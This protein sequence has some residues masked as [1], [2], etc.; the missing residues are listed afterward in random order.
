[1]NRDLPASF[2]Y[3]PAS[4][5]GLFAK[6]MA[7]EATAL[8][9][10]LEDSVSPA[11]KNTARDNL[12]SFLDAHPIPSKPVWVR[13]NALSDS[14]QNIAALDV[15][16]VLDSGISEIVVPK[17]EVASLRS[18]AQLAPE[19][20]VIGM[21]ETARGYLQLA[22]IAAE[23][24][25]AGLALGRADLLSELRIDPRLE[26]AFEQLA[27][28]LTVACAALGLPAPIAPAHL[29]LVKGDAA[30]A[31]ARAV[32]ERFFDLGF[33]SQ[34]SLHPRRCSTINSVFTPSEADYLKATALMTKFNTSN[35]SFVA[36][37]GQFVDEAVIRRS[38]EIMRRYEGN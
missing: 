37:D 22:E 25:V 33:R 1:M 6:A 30:E 8:I 10:D 34:T 5:P 38:R 7:S 19:L 12:R 14:S 21:V 31:E 17:T 26:S 15:Q 27:L 24:Q 36:D 2:L 28:P 11:D 4:Q 3:V 16:A 18:L 9:I 23:P 35:G 13:I 29:S 20:A 32:S